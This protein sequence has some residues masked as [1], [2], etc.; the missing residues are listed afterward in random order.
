MGR[1]GVRPTGCLKALAT[2]LAA[3]TV[4]PFDSLCDCRVADNPVTY[5][6]AAGGRRGGRLLT[7]GFGLTDVL[8]IDQET[9]IVH[10]HPILDEE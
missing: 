8:G 2:D 5:A 6:R 3:M 7:G 9:T 4:H 10:T 1:L